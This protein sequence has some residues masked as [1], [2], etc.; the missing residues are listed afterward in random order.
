MPNCW[1]VLMRFFLRVDGTLVRL[2]EARLFCDLRRPGRQVPT[3]LMLQHALAHARRPCRQALDDVHSARVRSGCR[4]DARCCDHESQSSIFRLKYLQLLNDVLKLLS[5]Q[6]GARGQA[7]GGD[8]G[9]AVWQRR[10]GKRGEI[11][12]RNLL[13]HGQRGTEGST[14]SEEVP[15]CKH[16]AAAIGGLLTAAQASALSACEE[17]PLQQICHDMVCVAPQVAHAD[18]DG[19]ALALSAIAPNGVKLF[20]TEALQF[21]E[22]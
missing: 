19:A 14:A 20:R 16:P 3:I 9:E 12:G 21:S 1:Y 22:S 7:R 17:S 2:R 5:R 4:W 13:R 10:I 15:C 11:F 18:A 6:A 8:A